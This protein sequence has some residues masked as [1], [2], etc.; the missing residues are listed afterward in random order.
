MFQDTIT[1]LSNIEHE[2]P[3]LTSKEERTLIKTEQIRQIGAL[4]MVILD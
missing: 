2:A 4:I 3:S 1:R